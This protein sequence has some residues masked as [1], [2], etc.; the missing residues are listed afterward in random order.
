MIA[1]YVHPSDVLAYLDAGWR[2]VG[3][4]ERYRSQVMVADNGTTEPTRGRKLTERHD[5][6]L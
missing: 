1:R 3:I 5:D 6:D 2:A 4:D